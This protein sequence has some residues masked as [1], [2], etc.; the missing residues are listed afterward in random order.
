MKI[1]KH[2]GRCC[3]SSVPCCFGQILF[4]ITDKNPKAC[5]ACQKID[6]LYWCGLLLNPI[7]WFTPMVGNIQWKCE[8][9][10]DIAKIYIGIGDGCGMNP[11][12]K[13]I[14]NQMQKWAKIR[15]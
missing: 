3:L 8:A 10:A 11:T 2:C 13:Q 12:Q 9:M 5:P 4:D 1:C 6:K 15:K 14:V 7:E